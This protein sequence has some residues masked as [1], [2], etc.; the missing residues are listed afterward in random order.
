[1][2][3]LALNTLQSA[4]QKACYTM[5]EFPSLRELTLGDLS[6]SLLLILQRDQPT[7]ISPALRVFYLL[8]A[9]HRRY[10]K[11]H[12]EL[13]LCQTLGRIMTLPAVARQGP[14]RPLRL[15][16]GLGSGQSTPKTGGPQLAAAPR[17]AP[18]G[19]AAGQEAVAGLG[20]SG[21]AEKTTS[22]A[23]SRTSN[24][25]RPSVALANVRSESDVVQRVL[26]PLLENECALT[27]EQE[28]ELY[29]DASLRTGTRGRL[30][31]QETRRQLV[32]GLHHLLI[33]DES[34]IT[35]LWVNYDCDMQSGDMF[36]FVTAFIAHRAVP[37]P[38]APSDA[39][40]E[41]FLDIMLYHLVR[42][43]GRAG[44]APPAGKWAQLL[45]LPESAYPAGRA[46]G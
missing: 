44:V 21:S 10:T 5:A 7:L 30:A 13:F 33:G 38:D 32:E 40:D 18:D 27:Y 24:S 3:L 12:L 8:F 31:T 39:E 34:L 36:D 4:F 15:G 20:I 11:G 42:T 17:A 45:G 19:L 29:N 26:P 35:D 25:R 1:M 46:T 28:V 16:S 37:W 43:A 14:R 23:H 2:R 22:G 41:A 9:S 6:H